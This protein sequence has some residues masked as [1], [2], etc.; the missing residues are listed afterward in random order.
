[1]DEHKKVKMYKSNFQ[2]SRISLA[3][4]EKRGKRGMEE[5]KSNLDKEGLAA[6]ALRAAERAAVQHCMSG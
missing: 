6:A 5:R 3:K 1:M 4:S 2:V